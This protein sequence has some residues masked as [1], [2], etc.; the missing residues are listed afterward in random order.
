MAYGKIIRTDIR[1]Y[2]KDLKSCKS[3]LH[4][5]HKALALQVMNVLF[6]VLCTSAL[7]HTVCFSSIAILKNK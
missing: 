4:V 2:S 1:Y 6:W 7:P 5:K 3:M